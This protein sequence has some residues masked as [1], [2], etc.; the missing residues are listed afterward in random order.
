MIKFIIEYYFWMVFLIYY[1]EFGVSDT[2]KLIVVLCDNTIKLIVL[3][4]DDTA[5][6]LWSCIV[7]LQK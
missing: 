7:I 6:L 2:I 4:Y 5:N 3:L 1:N